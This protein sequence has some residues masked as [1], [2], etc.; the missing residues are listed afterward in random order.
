MSTQPNPLDPLAA[1]IADRVWALLQERIADS[2][3]VQLVGVTEAAKRMG[4]G[5]SKLYEMIAREDFPRK[6]IR[7]IGRRTLVV[8]S[9]M[10]RWVSAQ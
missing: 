5:K 10:E 4:I 6:A 3:A 7:Q 8:V 1:A 9:E 2:Q